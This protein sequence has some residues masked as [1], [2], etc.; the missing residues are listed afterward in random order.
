MENKISFNYDRAAQILFVEDN[1]E[2]KTPAD[3]D[4]FFS[5]YERFMATIRE[6]FWM[7]AHIDHLVI[8]ADVAEYYGERARKATNSLILGLARWGTDSAARMAIRTTAMKSRMPVKVY[9]SRDEAIRA[10]DE[11]KAQIVGA[12]M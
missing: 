3:A 4:A 2:V 12:R 11:M 8:H 6:K 7:V 9:A 5:Q 10:I 1:W